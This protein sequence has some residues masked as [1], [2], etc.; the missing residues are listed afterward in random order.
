[1]GLTYS[2]AKSLG[3][4]HLHPSATV[5]RS[6]QQELIDRFAPAP[7]S[8]APDDGLNKTERAFRDDVLEPAKSR[9]VIGQWWREPVKLRLAGRTWYTPDYL[10]ASAVSTLQLFTFIEIKGWLREDAAI[11]VKVAAEM[12]PYFRW[13]LVYREGRHGW[14]VHHV[15]DR[16]ISINP[17]SV[18][19]I[20][21]G[22]S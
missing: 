13:L 16:G 7:P 1:M 5:D 4:G 17:I 22:G 21:G 9:Y 3:I 12:Y 14:R 10:V 11:K 20:P 2:Q 6:A 15:T 8:R 18:P 19:W